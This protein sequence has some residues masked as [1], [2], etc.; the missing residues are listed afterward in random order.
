MDN[1]TVEMTQT[2][3][4]LYVVWW[5]LWPSL[6]SKLGV[7]RCDPVLWSTRPPH[8]AAAVAGTNQM[9]T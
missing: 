1:S 8:V 6:D 4:D 5:H 9:L 7:E 2:F 3:A